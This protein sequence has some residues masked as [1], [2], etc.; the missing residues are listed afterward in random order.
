MRNTLGLSL[1]VG[2]LVWCTSGWCEQKQLDPG[3]INGWIRSV[4]TSGPP[5]GKEIKRIVHST[6]MKDWTTSSGSY[7]TRYEVNNAN[8]NRTLTFYITDELGQPYYKDWIPLIEKDQQRESP[9]LVR[10]KVFVQALHNPRPNSAVMVLDVEYQVQNGVPVLVASDDRDVLRTVREFKKGFS[11]Q[12]RISAFDRDTS[13]YLDLD[14]FT[15]KTEWSEKHCPDDGDVEE[16]GD[17][18]SILSPASS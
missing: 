16:T 9:Q 2:S 12:L 6:T 7:H 13:F 10:P 1:I 18:N 8:C 5:V 15:D 17:D 14:G 3:V 4:E 11:A